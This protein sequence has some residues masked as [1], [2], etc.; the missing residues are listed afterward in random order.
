MSADKTGSSGF[1]LWRSFSTTIL[2]S[3]GPAPSLSSVTFFVNFNS[4]ATSCHGVPHKPSQFVD[5]QASLSVCLV[6]LLASHNSIL[7][8]AQNCS[9]SIMMTNED[10]LSLAAFEGTDTVFSNFTIPNFLSK[11]RHWLLNLRRIEQR[12]LRSPRRT[13]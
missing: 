8:N 9:C 11:L 3:G 1:N 2:G 4:G 6:Q 13:A 12:S 5:S 10:Q 7:G